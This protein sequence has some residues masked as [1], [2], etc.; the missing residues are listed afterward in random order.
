[1]RLKMWFDGSCLPYNPG[2]T[3]IGA[4]IIK[5]EDNLIVYKNRYREDHDNINS[6]NYAEHV[7]LGLG[8]AWLAENGQKV[9]EV[10]IYGDSKLVINQMKGSYRINEGTHYYPAA[11]QNKDIVWQYALEKKLKYKWIPR[12]LNWEADELTK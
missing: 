5:D 1:M 4:V 2:K 6:C 9:D 7:G 8:L 12:E 11:K 3:T 10:I